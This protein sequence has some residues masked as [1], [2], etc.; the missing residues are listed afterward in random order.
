LSSI[1]IALV[2]TAT[3]VGSLVGS[4]GNKS[5]DQR[6]SLELLAEAWTW[7]IFEV[8]IVSLDPEHV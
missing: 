2:S 4:E 5:F 6:P 8:E 3:V 7:V 1:L